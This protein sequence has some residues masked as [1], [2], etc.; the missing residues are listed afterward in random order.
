MS[1]E[2]MAVFDKY[3]KSAAYHWRKMQPSVR[4]RS[5]IL[6]ARYQEILRLVGRMDGH[7]VLDVGCGD[8]CLSAL[9]GQRGAQ[10]AGID[11]SHEAIVLAAEMCEQASVPA[12]FVEGAGERLPVDSATQ[13]VVVC[14]DVIEHVE[15]PGALLEEIRRVLRPTGR[16]VLSTPV[17][18]A[19]GR[20]HDPL[21]SHEFSGDELRELL[22]GV[23]TSTD[24]SFSHPAWLGHAYVGRRRAP[25]RYVVN[26][27]DIR[28][29]WNAFARVRLGKRYDEM[30]AVCECQEPRGSTDVR[31]AK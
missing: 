29:H 6:S 8:G 15:Q 1:A 10:V 7:D 22:S 24:M 3:D 14:C 13:D 12:R 5:A 26:W 28:A 19:D 21:H 31:E 25:V 30:Y 27:L 4:T 17:A 11:S 16:L 18:R 20:L 2:S 23:F 9:L